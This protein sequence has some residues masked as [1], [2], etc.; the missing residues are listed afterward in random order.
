MWPQQKTQPAYPWRYRLLLALLLIAAAGL[1]WRM[2]Y[3]AVFNRNFLQQQSD[4][5]TLRVVP[6]PAYRGMITDRNGTPIAISTPVDSV[7]ID[8]QEFDEKDPR[9]AQLAQTLA[10]PV[11]ELQARVN[12]NADREFVYLKRSLDPATGQTIRALRLPGVGLQREYR[13]FYPQGEVTAHLLGFTNIDDH[14]QEGL[15]LAYDQ[16]LGGETG[17]KRVLKDRM[18]RTVQEINTLREPRPGHDLKLSIDQRIQYLAYSEL[19]AGLAKF[20]AE[21]G[22]A[23]V[24]DVNTGEILAMVNQPSYNPNNRPSEHDGRYRNRAVTDLF[25]PGSTIKT[26][27]TLSAL[28]SGKYQSTTLVDTNPGYIYVDGNR[29]QDDDGHNNGV[30]DLTTILARSS[31]VGIAKITLSL[32]ADNLWQVLHAVGFGQSV[33]IGFPGEVAGSLVHRNP[34]HSF[35]LATLSFGYG[36]SAN[37]LQLAQAYTILANHGVK[38]PLSLLYVDHPPIGQQVLETAPVNKLLEMLEAVSKQGGTAPLA[39]VPGYRVAGKTGTARMVGARGYEKN[40]HNSSFVGIA[41]ASNPRL[42][43]AV[44]L[45]DP[46]GKYY[47]GGY[48][49]GPI[50]SNIMGESL[51]LLDV[52]PDDLTKKN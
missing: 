51:R 7:W 28:A 45:H 52:P 10:M 2:V 3:L 35:A 31:N 24:L 18:G 48:T 1:V 21:S 39:R 44:F 13:R 5:R 9:I 40:H 42:L 27:S 14:G 12:K 19:K 32:P 11:A 25:E 33:N 50:F 30:I 43:V 46:S 36:M 38:K 16:W 49:A 6:M 47:L 20:Q 34:W 23:I 29:V 4:A 17:L 8:P 15:E 26:F 22:S 37:L 41:P